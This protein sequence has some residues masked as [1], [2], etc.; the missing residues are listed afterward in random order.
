MNI[1]P[2]FP[3]PGA[4]TSLTGGISSEDEIERSEGAKI[5]SGMVLSIRSGSGVVIPA[6]NES[7][8]P[9]VVE[10]EGFSARILRVSYTYQRNAPWERE[11]KVTWEGKPEKTFLDLKIPPALVDLYEKINTWQK[12]R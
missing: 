10:V 6:P 2:L 5:L 9:Y 3:A 11:L 1:R 12:T 7:S 4:L 8:R